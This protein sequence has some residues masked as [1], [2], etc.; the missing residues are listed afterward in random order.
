MLS[1]IFVHVET[2][3]PCVYGETERF[4]EYRGLSTFMYLWNK[5]SL[6]KWKTERLYINRRIECFHMY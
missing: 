1:N 3:N 4:Y 2:E 6:Y 5:A